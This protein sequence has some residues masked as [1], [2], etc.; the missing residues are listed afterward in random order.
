MDTAIK[1]ATTMPAGRIE[2]EIFF[3]DGEGNLFEVDT[4]KARIMPGRI[5]LRLK[6]REGP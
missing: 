6:K 1:Y 4:S 5:L 2:P 3:S